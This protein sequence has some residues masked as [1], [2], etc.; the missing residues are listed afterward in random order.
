MHRTQAGKINVRSASLQ[1]LTNYYSIKQKGSES[2]NEYKNRLTA[3]IER[4]RSADSDEVPS[5]ADQARK[6]TTSLDPRRFNR[7]IMD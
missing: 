2:L 4:I 6:F 7:L 5:D 3:A 1:V